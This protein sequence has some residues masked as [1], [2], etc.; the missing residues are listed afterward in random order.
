MCRRS[1]V[2]G[3]KVVG[4]FDKNEITL[5][6]LWLYAVWVLTKVLG[7]QHRK[8][9]TSKGLRITSKQPWGVGTSS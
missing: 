5:C 6:E 4:D 2:C 1:E 8:G 7:V 3:Y 9:K